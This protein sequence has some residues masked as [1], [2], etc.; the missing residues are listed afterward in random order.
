MRINRAPQ[1]AERR[2]IE[3]CGCLPPDL[4]PAGLFRW[5]ARIAGRPPA[6]QRL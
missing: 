1:G 5:L 4:D 3:H 6:G 2:L